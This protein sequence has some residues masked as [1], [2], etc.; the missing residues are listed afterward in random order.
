MEFGVK[1]TLNLDGFVITLC[2]KRISY[3]IKSSDSSR[4]ASGVPL[5]K[6]AVSV[7]KDVKKVLDPKKDKAKGAGKKGSAEQNWAPCVA[8]V[9]EIAKVNCPIPSLLEGEV[10]H[11]KHR[12]HH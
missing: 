5:Q 6:G 1:D 8:E 12:H 2:Y 11:T 3:M 9:I 7:K 10:T 4:P